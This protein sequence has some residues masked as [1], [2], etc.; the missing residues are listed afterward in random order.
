MNRLQTVE[1]ARS[2]SAKGTAGK[3]KAKR[4]R[5]HVSPTLVSE[6]RRYFVAPTSTPDS[7]K[8]LDLTDGASFSFTSHT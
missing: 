5:A 6:Y 7:F 8:V 4:R 3:V 2:K 1:A